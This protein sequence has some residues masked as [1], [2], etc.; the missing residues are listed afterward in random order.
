VGWSSR[1]RGAATRRLVPLAAAGATVASLSGGALQSAPPA[2][3]AAPPAR[4]AA[5][6]TIPSPPKD[7]SVS[8]LV[9]ATIRKKGSVTAA[10]DATY[11]PDEFVAANG[12]TIIGMDAD[13]QYAL[14]DVMGIKTTLVNATFDSIIGGIVAGR[15]DVGNSSFTVTAQREQQVNF[16][17][18]FKAGE[19]FYV[20]ASST[21]KLN[22]LPSLCGLKVSVETGTTEQT[23]AE[24]TVKTCK[25]AHKAPD[26][27][28]P[29]DTQ[30]EANLAVS[31][32]RADLGFADSQ[33]AAYIVHQSNG[34]FKLDG[35]AIEV[36]P[37]G[38]AFPK[39]SRLDVAE[40]AA[41]K[42]LMKDGIYAKI[43]AK[44]GTETGAITNPVINPK[45]G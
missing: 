26:T 31:T 2:A 17:T 25:A 32:G 37:Y 8:A 24:N 13:F 35:A 43:L 30:N 38:F 20:N 39:G 40:L 29:F 1:S 9:P 36:A 27:V 41:L 22:G 21:L 34:Q 45:V 10:M 16:V 28:L 7:P 33:V 44:W 5:S 15:Y 4:A 3:A 42:V 19:A 6:S 18:Y 12:K 14:D 11:P 23:D